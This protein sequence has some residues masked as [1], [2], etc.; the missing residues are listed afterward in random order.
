[1]PRVFAF[2]GCFVKWSSTQDEGS[3]IVWFTAVLSS[4]LF[5]LVEP[6]VQVAV[7]QEGLIAGNMAEQKWE[8]G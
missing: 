2:S 5:S 8:E 7:I 4:A 1:M 6:C 3:A